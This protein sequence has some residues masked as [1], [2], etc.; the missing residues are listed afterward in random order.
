MLLRYG[1]FDSPVPSSFHLSDSRCHDLLALAEAQ[2]VEGI[3]AAAVKKL[4][5]SVSVPADVV[6]RLLV[7]A[8]TIRLRSSK[9]KSLSDKI[10]HEYRS[11][12]L[13]PLLMKGPAVAVF[14]PEPEL[15]S[16]GDIDIY[17]PEGEFDSAVQ[18][19][20]E[21]G[22]SLKESPDGSVQYR[23][24]GI[25]I[26][27]HRKYFDLHIEA[28]QLPDP[29]TPE[30]CL[31]MLSCHIL[32]HSMGPGIGI[33]QLCD[34]ALAY[35]SLAFDSARLK[36]TYRRSGTQRWNRLLCAFLRDYLDTDAGL[37]PGDVS[38]SG[39]LAKIVFSAGDFG[40]HSDSRRRAVAS[41]ENRRK[42]DTLMHFVR[43]IPFSLKYAP[44]EFRSYFA[45]LVKGNIRRHRS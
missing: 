2:R 1:L 26:D 29:N 21:S 32:K 18:L 14:Y 35:R 8:A 9:L 38:S 24:D 28:E 13:H 39:P 15:R 25:L 43:R 22:T 36:E 5:E 34:I 41:G 40:Y 44:G 3:I 23:R 30:A 7:D 45:E 19:L 31:L 33:R 10:L 42:L 20:R 27:Q 37:F 6:E 4:D 16:S 11:A 17:L 12:G